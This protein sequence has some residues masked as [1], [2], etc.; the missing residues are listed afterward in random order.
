MNSIENEFEKINKDFNILKRIVLLALALLIFLCTGCEKAE[1]IT[2]ELK[3]E[4]TDIYYRV[5]F[6]KAFPKR[7]IAT[8]VNATVHGQHL[9]QVVIDTVVYQSTEIRIVKPSGLYAYVS[10][11]VIPID[12][13]DTMR[14]GIDY[15]ADSDLEVWRGNSCAVN[16][17]HIPE[18][19]INL[20]N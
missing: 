4:S 7:V 6:E 15:V 18:L 1:V 12:H 5:W 9:D 14:I 17:M 3:N 20:K 2:P 10:L 13:T 16:A 11:S 8:L 19:F